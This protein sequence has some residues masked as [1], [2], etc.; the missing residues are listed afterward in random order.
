MI[1]REQ[2]LALVNEWVPNKNLVKHMLCLEACMEDYAERLGQDKNLW[3]IT[4]LLHDADWEKHPDFHPAKIIEYLR[5][6]NKIDPT[7]APE[8]MIHAIASH[9]NGEPRFAMRNTPIDHYLYACDEL[10]GFVVA[11]ALVRPEKLT[12]IKVSS[13]IKRLKDKSFAK[14]VNRADITEGLGVIGLTLDE[15]VQNVINSIT[16]IRADIGL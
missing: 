12:G 5:E 1:T 16:R 13:V 4:G 15:H 8:E 6:Q 3:G 9:G 10:S 2:A 14:G 7:F 11:V